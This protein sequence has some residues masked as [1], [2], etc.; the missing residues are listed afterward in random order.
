M[1]FDLHLSD[2]TFLRILQS[3]GLMLAGWLISNLA[4][5]IIRRN[6]DDAQQRFKV[7]RKI[8]R[9]VGLIALVVIVGIWSPSLQSLLTGL[10]IIGTGLAIALREV[11]L[12]F[13]GWIFIVVRR[14]YSV[15]DRI[16]I[17]GLSGDVLDIRLLS[18]T[19]METRDWVK[20]D[21]ST[22]RITQFPNNWV[23]Q[24]AVKNFTQGFD[25]IWNEIAFTLTLDSDW[26]AAREAIMTLA[27]ESAEIVAHQVRS[28]LKNMADAFLVHYSILTPF[29]YVKVT[30]YGIELTLRYLCR[31]R[32]RRGSDH[33]LTISI[34][35]ALAELEK[36]K[37]TTRHCTFDSRQK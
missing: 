22:G 17:N 27:E 31:A 11:V 34:L 1:P 6:I 9:I 18:T 3:I 12:S 32:N 35:A 36:V 37:L 15:G 26:E 5:R 16:E 7:G 30:D 4:R 29:V 28:Q 24:F 20:A 13:I 2:P 21:Q 14:P 8:N 23:Y 33:A 10:T 25:Y 19:L